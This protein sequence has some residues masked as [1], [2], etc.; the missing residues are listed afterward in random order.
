[1]II[2]RLALGHREVRSLVP[3]KARQADDGRWRE[4]ESP[5]RRL[6]ALLGAA[7]VRERP[8]GPRLEP[9]VL[10]QHARFV[11]PVPALDDAHS[12]SA[13]VRLRSEADPAVPDVHQLA[14][15]VLVDEVAHVAMR[16]R[17]QQ[18]KVLKLL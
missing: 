8:E 6:A 5:Q 11:R 14:R 3:G 4:T 12:L 7:N 1:E 17:R 15:A 16:P 18:R 9:A 2:M 13:S 10:D